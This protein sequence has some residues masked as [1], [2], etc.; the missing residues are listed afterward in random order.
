MTV[1]NMTIEAGGRAGMIAPDD[2]TFEWVDGPR[3]GARPAAARRVARAAHRR[4]RRVRHARSRSTPRSSRRRSPGGPRRAMVDRRDR[5]GARAARRGRGARAR[6]H[7]ARGRH[8]DRGD[9]RST[10]SSSAPAPTRASA[11]C[12]RPP[13]WSR[14]RKVAASVSAMVVPGSQ[15][16]K[17][18]GRGRGSRRGVPRRR[19]RLALGRLLDVPGHEPRHPPARRALR[20]DLEPQL[21][22]TPGPRR[23]HSPGQPEDGRRGRDRGPLRR[24]P[25]WEPAWSR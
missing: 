13:R 4:R 25:G 17:A 10:A 11:T 20:V 24:H 22:G 1:C 3:G 5:R 2:T 8:A 19:L 21:R 9:P 7:G 6:V 14:G 15:Q 16:V 23:A 18:A 12:A